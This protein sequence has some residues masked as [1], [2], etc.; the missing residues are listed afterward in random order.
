MATLEDPKTATYEHKPLQGPT[1][2]SNG[3]DVKPPTPKTK[4]HSLVNKVKDMHTWTR[5]YIEDPAIVVFFS[6]LSTQT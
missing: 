6:W 1:L 2:S 5:Y 4:M 3:D